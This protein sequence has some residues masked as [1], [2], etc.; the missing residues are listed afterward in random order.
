MASLDDFYRKDCG[1][2]DASFISAYIDLMY[3]PENATGIILDH[4]WGTDKLDLLPLIK[5]GETVT[6]LELLEDRLRFN[7]EDGEADCIYGDD[8]SRIISL[9]LLKD[10]DQD[11]PPQNGDILIYRDGKWYAFDFATWQNNIDNSVSNMK[12]RINTLENKVAN[13]EAKLTP[14][15]NIPSNARIT[16]GVIN[17]YGDPNNT[18]DKTKGLYSHDPNT[19]VIGDQKFA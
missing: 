17:N 13:I 15:A 10:V 7:R 14:P 19:D 11:T 12:A 1:K 6:S 4:S 2:I 3:D 18:G 8:L 9:N 16:W 5:A